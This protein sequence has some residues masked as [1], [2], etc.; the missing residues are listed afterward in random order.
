MSFSRPAMHV[1]GK[2]VYFARVLFLE[3]RHR[4]S[5]NQTEHNQ[6]FHMCRRELDLKRCPKF[7]SPFPECMAQKLTIFGW[8][9]VITWTSWERNELLTNWKYNCE[10][11]T[12]FF[13][14]LVNFDRL[15][16]EIKWRIFARRSPTT[17]LPIAIC[18][19]VSQIWKCVF[20]LLNFGI[21]SL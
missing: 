16:A 5:P 20:K 13:Q 14:N 4:R 9:Y 7:V 6:A 19:A 17:T 15:T 12:A 8:F 3:C 21:P 1:N 2:P 10:G 11:F 18:S